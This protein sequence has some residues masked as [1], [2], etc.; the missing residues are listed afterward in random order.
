MSEAPNVRIVL[1]DDHAIT[2][3]GIRLVLAGLT[4]L[5]LVGE[6][7]D[8]D[9]ALRL[10]Q[11][12]KPDILLLDINLPGRHGLQVAR[13]LR[14]ADLKTRIVILT[15][16]DG[17]SYIAATRKLGVHGFVSK[18]AAAQELVAAIRLVARGLTYFPTEAAGAGDAGAPGPRM[19]PTPAERLVLELVAEGNSNRQI[20]EQLGLS[21]RTVQFHLSNLFAKAQ[22]KSRTGLVHVARDLAWLG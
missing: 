14:A 6:A 9:A 18:V 11:Q 20:A 22:V 7:A 21:A 15:G 17:E 1:A 5:V 16:Y 2:R 4:D 10:V 19:L 13:W 8:G 12:L 3:E